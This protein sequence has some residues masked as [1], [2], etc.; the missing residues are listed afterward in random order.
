MTT[1]YPMMVKLQG[2]RCVVVGGGAVAERKVR[3]LLEGG[4]DQ[5]QVIA[6]A[7]APG[8]LDLAEGSRCIRLVQREYREG[9][10][11]GAFLVMAATDDRL[12]NE[13][14]AAAADR[15]GI[16]ANTAHQGDEGSFLSPS[17]V[18]RGEL[19][20]AVTTGGASPALAGMIGQELS[21]QFGE[22]YADLVER[23]RLL[24]EHVLANVE[25]RTLRAA[26]L[27][28]AAQEAVSLGKESER[29]E[30]IPP[31]RIEE[32]MMRLRQAAERSG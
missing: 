2:K 17:A 9:D 22:Q 18:R 11:H 13:A 27:R 23:L 21:R 1:Y 3:G 24:R 5:V 14:I 30:A 8:L 6:P 12:V 10:L 16:L 28:Q 15:L 29:R 26:I 31:E 4:A 32:W 25:D 20:L 19:L 7:A